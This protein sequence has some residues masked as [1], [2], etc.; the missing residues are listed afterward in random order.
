MKRH[1]IKNEKRQDCKNQQKIS[2]VCHGATNYFNYEDNI[3]SKERNI[4]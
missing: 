4:V 2:K 3:K 1:Q